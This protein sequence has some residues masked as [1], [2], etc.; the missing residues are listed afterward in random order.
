MDIASP[1][2]A[3]EDVA[4]LGPTLAA[5][6]GLIW[7]SFI[8][9]LI[10]RLPLGRS[11]VFPPSACPSCQARVAPYDNIPVLSYIFLGGRCRH[12]RT[13]ISIRYPFVEILVAAGSWAAYH[14]HGFTI[15]YGV[16]FGFVAAMVALVFIDYDHRILPNVITIPGAIVGLLLAFVRE[17]ITPTE[18]LVGAGLG[19]GLLF[20][21]AEAYFRLRR[22][23]GLGMGDVKMMAMVGA[24]LGWKGVLL[25]LLVGSF[26]GS[27]VGLALMAT[28]G[29]SLKTA[30]PFGTFLGMAATAT[31]FGG[32][33]LIDWYFSLF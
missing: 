7:G 32:A 12:C 29:K 14:R 25:T 15:E 18:A 22:V 4:W 5:V 8:N 6:F 19:A 11:V 2:S 30:L 10:Y 1:V 9:V 26:L 24:F 20:A 3:V 21:V 27:L 23:E 31:V 28:Q 13:R 33:P 17:A 16:E